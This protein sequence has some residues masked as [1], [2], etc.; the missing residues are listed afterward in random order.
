[1]KENAFVL[2]E[3]SQGLKGSILKDSRDERKVDVVGSHQ[4]EIS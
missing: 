2:W 3:Y 4:S 1:M